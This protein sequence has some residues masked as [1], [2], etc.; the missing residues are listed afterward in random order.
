MKTW[1]SQT[2]GIGVVTGVRLSDGTRWGSYRR[3]RDP[4]PAEIAENE[5]IGKLVRECTWLPGPGFPKS[6]G[7]DDW[8]PR[9]RTWDPGWKTRGRRK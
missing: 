7:A 6:W 5:R 8:N 2:R 1:L 3:E 9:T 4:A